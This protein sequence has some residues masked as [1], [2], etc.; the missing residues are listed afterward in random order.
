M[1]KLSMRKLVCCGVWLLMCLKLINCRQLPTKLSPRIV[2][3]KYGQI[4]GILVDYQPTDSVLAD[5][6]GQLYQQQ[7]Q[8]SPLSN[9]TAQFNKFVNLNSNDNLH[10]SSSHSNVHSSNNNLGNI[11]IEAF[12]GV[13]YAQPPTGD[14][15]F[16][17]PV[18][19][20]HWRGIK[21]VDQF[22][23]VCIQ[24]LPKELQQSSTDQG[25]EFNVFRSNK[26]EQSNEQQSNSEDNESSFY[27]LANYLRNSS[28]D[29]LY[30]NIYVPNYNKGNYFL[31]CSF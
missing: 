20:G 18:S 23:P 21:V 30:L 4:R 8:K 5:L 28:E 11:Q 25:F 15:R 3:T 6:H 7:A 29:C 31:I 1:T 27:S 26:T 9:G 14:R 17:P 12:L 24:K 19:P 13:S 2:K 10:S 16:L 22:Q